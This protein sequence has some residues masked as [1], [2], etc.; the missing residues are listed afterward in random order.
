MGPEDCAWRAWLGT[1]LG[2]PGQSRPLGSWCKSALGGGQVSG[3]Q[4]ATT[5]VCFQEG[6]D[7]IRSGF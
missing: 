6:C 7:M 1:T 3:Q 5:L 4:G 2:V